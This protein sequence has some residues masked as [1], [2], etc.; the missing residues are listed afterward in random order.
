MVCEDHKGAHA[1]QSRKEQYESSNWQAL[2]S[3]EADSST[4]I[5]DEALFLFS[6][7]DNPG[8]T[9]T[10]VLRGLYIYASNNLTC[11]VVIPEKILS[12]SNYITSLISLFVAAE[13]FIPIK[14]GQRV[15]CNTAHLYPGIWIFARKYSGNVPQFIG[16]GEPLVL[17]NLKASE[18]HTPP[19]ISF[20]LNKLENSFIANREIQAHERVA[21]LKMTGSAATTPE[22]SF[23]EE[24]ASLFEAHDYH[25]FNPGAL[26]IVEV[27]S[28][29]SR[30]QEVV[31]SWGA[32]GY[33]ASYFIN[34]DANVLVLGH[35]GY[36]SEMQSPWSLINLYSMPCAKIT[37]LPGLKTSPTRTT[38]I[39]IQQ[40]LM[41]SIEANVGM[42][43]RQCTQLFLAYL[44]RNP[45]AAELAHHGSKNYSA[46]KEEI[47]LCR[48]RKNIELR[49][50]TEKLLPLAYELW[51]A[52]H[53][54]IKPTGKDIRLSCRLYIAAKGSS[55]YYENSVPWY[56]IL[57]DTLHKKA[58]IDSNGHF[59]HLSIHGRAVGPE[60]P[61]RLSRY[62]LGLAHIY[63]EMFCDNASVVFVTEPLYY[64]ANCYTGWN[65]GHDLSQ[66]L[67]SIK[68]YLD[69][70][71]LNPELEPLRVVLSEEAI[72]KSKNT[73]D[74][75]ESFIPRERWFL[76][77]SNCV[78]E[79]RHLEVP[80]AKYFDLHKADGVALYQDAMRRV[81]KD[82]EFEL[83]RSEAPLP[84]NVILAKLET[85]TFARK[86]GII[87]NFFIDKLSEIWPGWV[88]IDPEKLHLFE[89]AKILGQCQRVILGNGAVGYAHSALIR[90]EATVYVPFSDHMYLP[91]GLE[92][93]VLLD[94]PGDK[95]FEAEAWHELLER[96]R[97]D[98]A[99]SLQVVL[100][101]DASNPP[102][103]AIG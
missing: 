90:S 4:L 45:S 74:L 38:R 44:D 12:I 27:Y 28:R 81:T 92:R 10:N 19:E 17:H 65:I 52:G 96:L 16:N 102:A 51:S 32:L 43:A 55:P 20:L 26:S 7:D 41:E 72:E 29:L 98:Y 9:F 22:R 67:F 40:F 99:Y 89:I 93:C 31:V 56:I 86:S 103:I 87:P 97:V 84:S 39:N 95:C 94:I 34:P 88:V 36:I 70:C 21:L 68:Y 6:T 63:G 18:F 60:A 8:H 23:S 57:V 53:R 47:E 14:S 82:K 85:H 13:N 15:H 83:Y 1:G 30:A 35:E 59:L 11:P 5:L 79:F 66:T 58:V 24:Y 76:V 61:W 78:Y 62:L 73:A 91:F 54:T 64:L 80:P 49:P 3:E 100:K 37:M 71:S 46:F 2:L 50:L 77:K 48:E 42:T 69:L 75:I 25:F 33:M 101:N